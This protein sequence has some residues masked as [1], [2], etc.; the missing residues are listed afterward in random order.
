MCLEATLC[1]CSRAISIGSYK[2][3]TSMQPVFGVYFA[4]NRSSE[5]KG[6]ESRVSVMCFARKLLLEAEESA[7]DE[8]RYVRDSKWSRDHEIA[9]SHSTALTTSRKLSDHLNACQECKEGRCTSVAITNA[10]SSDPT[11]PVAGTS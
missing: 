6:Q 9:R 8:F 2:R 3:F 4:T 11:T 5:R 1:L 7:W 10:P